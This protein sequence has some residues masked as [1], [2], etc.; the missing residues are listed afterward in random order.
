MKR[1]NKAVNCSDMETLFRLT[2]RVAA[3]A[4]AGCCK[5]PRYEHS[6]PCVHCLVV[7][8]QGIYT[9]TKKGLSVALLGS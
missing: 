1:G 6:A 5:F 7:V 9:G 8:R 3:K 2:R 4:P